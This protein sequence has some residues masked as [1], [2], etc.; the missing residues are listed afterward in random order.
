MLT[1]NLANKIIGATLEEGGRL[2][3][4]P[5]CV[6]VL[7]AGGNMLALSRHEAASPYRPQIALGK[8]SAC[9]GLGIG[10]VKTQA[11]GTDRPAFAN[12][13]GSVFPGGFIPAQGGVLIKDEAGRILGAVGVTGD[14]S[15]KDE[16]AAV[17]GVQAVGLIADT[18]A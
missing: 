3:L 18:G 16:L 11:I 5:L 12:S 15:A 13:L 14:L 8:A 4:A 9:I 10:G 6:V 2:E 1:L 7:D 17:A